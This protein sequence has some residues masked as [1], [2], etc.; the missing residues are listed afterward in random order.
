MDFFENKIAQS[1]DKIPIIADSIGLEY[2]TGDGKVFFTKKEVDFFDH[3]F[4]ILDT[5]EDGY[6]NLVI[7]LVEQRR[8]F[9]IFN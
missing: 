8:N 4:Y 9:A 5:D 1:L 2:D 6:V 7:I 3:L